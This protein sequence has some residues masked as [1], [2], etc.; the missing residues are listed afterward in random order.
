MYKQAEALRL[1]CHC[2]PLNARDPR[3]AITRLRQLV[4][5]KSSAKESDST[6]STAASNVAAVTAPRDPVPVPLPKS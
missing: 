4:A 5:E 3:S 2:P 1:D 6:L